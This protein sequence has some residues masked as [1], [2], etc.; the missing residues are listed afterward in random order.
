LIQRDGA[1]EFELRVGADDLPWIGELPVRELELSISK[2]KLTPS[3]TR[4]RLPKSVAPGLR[5][6]VVA[7]A[8][9]WSPGPGPTEEPRAQVALLYR[10]SESSPTLR[11]L[12]LAGPPIVKGAPVAPMSDP[13]IVDVPIPA[14]RTVV[15]NGDV[16][17]RERVVRGL[18]VVTS[19][20]AG[21]AVG[22]IL[23]W[24]ER[25]S[26]VRKAVVRPQGI[27]VLV[28]TIFHGEKGLPPDNIALQV[29]RCGSDGSVQT[30][31]DFGNAFLRAERF[32]DAALS[33]FGIR[34]KGW[35][36]REFADL[37]LRWIFDPETATYIESHKGF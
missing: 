34:G 29:F 14:G 6:G 22:Q 16:E 4:V 23:R 20:K 25:T 35:R 31:V 32:E 27:D 36:P 19:H 30:L 2:S 12:D 24:D 28:E 37:D 11:F 18:R 17:I 26:K 10:P 5:A 33:T 15:S 1:T 13:V 21:N 3:P 9:W 7:E 8:L